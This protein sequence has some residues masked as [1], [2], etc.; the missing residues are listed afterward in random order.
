MPGR[1]EP[2]TGS[3]RSVTAAGS[4]IR[5]FQPGD[6]PAM[7]R[8]RQAAFEPVFRSFR[9]IVGEQIAALAFASAEA[10]QAKL[11]DDI[12]AAGSGHQV[13][14]VTIGDEIVGFVSFTVD[15]TTRLGEIGLNAV[16]P[17]HA[18]K[19]IGAEMYE[20]VLARMKERGM[21]IATV[22]TGGDPSH[23]PAR[24]AYEKAGFGPA[25]PSIT[26]YRLL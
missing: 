22:G 14:V 10:E 4:I 15:P 21:A 8:V 6:L 19:G 9:A 2:K 12:C 20:L 16:H 18:G 17:E 1:R 26:L 3:E 24:R 11:L 25:I 5:P 13:L 23:A 7:Q